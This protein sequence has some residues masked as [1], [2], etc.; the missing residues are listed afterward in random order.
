MTTA[1]HP[2]RYVAIG[3]SYA[4]GPGIDPAVGDRPAKA[5]QSLRNYPHLIAHRLGLDL[6][7]VT[8][9]GTT[10]QDILRR[11][12]FGQPPQIDAVTVQADLVTVTVGGNDIGYIPSLIEAFLPTWVSQMPVLGQRLRKATQPARADDRLIR[13]A[14]A[15][16]LVFAAIRVRA[17]AARIICV[18]YLTVLP[19]TYRSEFRFDD[20]THRALISLAG[21]LNDALARACADNHVELVQ[22]STPSLDH[23]AWSAEPWTT[24][25]IPPRPGR[26]A[27]AFHPTADG[28]SAIADMVADRLTPTD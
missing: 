10:T 27:A 9:S 1:A 15:T 26:A 21:D 7:D 13:T 17:P 22:A 3:S 5:R 24:G 14:T 28:M 18:D 2:R 20:H 25:W 19:L 23:H 6:A 12:Q 16:A 8:S 4:A 11:T